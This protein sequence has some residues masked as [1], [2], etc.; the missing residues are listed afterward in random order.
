MLSQPL[1]QLTA[2]DCT[3]PLHNVDAFEGMK[4]HRQ[5]GLQEE[6]LMTRDLDGIHFVVKRVTE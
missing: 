3:F 6:V 1:P 2:L 4:A 5:L